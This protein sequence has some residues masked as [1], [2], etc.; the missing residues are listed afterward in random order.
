[1]PDVKSDTF[2]KWWGAG[3]STLVAL[4]A[5]VVFISGAF[6]TTGDVDALKASI[7]KHHARP[8]HEHIVLEHNLTKQ[9]VAAIETAQRLNFDKF[10][11]KL[12]EQT[13][14]IQGLTRMLIEWTR[15]HGK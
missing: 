14:E 7:S 10:E 2:L 15:D 9:R 3:L 13:R 1:M 4:M 5:A 12:D 6:A 11:K 8:G